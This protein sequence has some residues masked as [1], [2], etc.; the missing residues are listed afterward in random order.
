MLDRRRDPRTDP[1]ASLR[2]LLRVRAERHGLGLAVISTADGVLVAGSREDRPARRAAAHA[3]DEVR[4]GAS[5]VRE[6]PGAR[7]RGVRV[8]YA[9]GPLVIAVLE[10]QAGPA[11]ENVLAGLAERIGAILSE[12]RR[13]AAA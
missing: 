7:L 5:F 1:H 2:N 3:A 8:D 10:Q 11:A 12:L 9:G 4:R 13:R 6:A